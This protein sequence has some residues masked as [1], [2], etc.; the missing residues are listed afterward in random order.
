MKYLYKINNIVK[1]YSNLKSFEDIKIMNDFEI[2]LRRAI[3]NNFDSC[4][5]DG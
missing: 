1:N 3:K 2:G 4:I 5:S